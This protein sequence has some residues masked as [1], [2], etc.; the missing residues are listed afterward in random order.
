VE[1]T[2][3]KGGK[4]TVV[5]VRTVSADGKTLTVTVKGTNAQGQAVNH[6]LVL[7]KS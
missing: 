7:E 1:T 2:Y 3:K 6:A 4:V 5:N